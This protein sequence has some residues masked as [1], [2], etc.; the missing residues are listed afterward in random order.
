[1]EATPTAT[2]VG[3]ASSARVASKGLLSR[4][5]PPAVVFRTSDHAY[6]LATDLHRPL[7]RS[8]AK[9]GKRGQAQPLFPFFPAL[10]LPR[11]ASRQKAQG[12]RV[13]PH[14]T[15]P[16]ET[17][18]LRGSIVL[19]PPAFPP[20]P[21]SPEDPEHKL[22]N[23]FRFSQMSSNGSDHSIVRLCLRLSGGNG[24]AGGMPRKLR[25]EYPGAIY[26]PP[27][28]GATAGQV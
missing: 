16:G 25:V 9:L 4:L 19:F 14:A 21:H 22:R 7:T 8:M 28:L 12:R 26:H 23:R 11:S 3:D 18:R 1:M 5:F 6:R 10:T 2:L 20:L 13:H 15:P 17:R 24:K 27:S